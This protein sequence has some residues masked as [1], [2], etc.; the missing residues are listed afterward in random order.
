M[1]KDGDKTKNSHFNTSKTQ[2]KTIVNQQTQNNRRFNSPMKL[3]KRS[4]SKSQ[5]QLPPVPTS[6]RNILPPI[7]KISKIEQNKPTPPIYTPAPS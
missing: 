5:Q 3:L 6:K 2:K 1:V 7:S 4:N